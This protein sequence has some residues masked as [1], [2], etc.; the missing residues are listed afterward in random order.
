M[1][2]YAQKEN[3]AK[4]RTPSGNIALFNGEDYMNVKYNKIESDYINDRNPVVNRVLGMPPS[5][6]II[7]KMKPRAVLK[8]DVS[9]ERMEPAMVSGLETNPYVIPLHKASQAI[10]DKK[11]VYGNN[12]SASIY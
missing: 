1:R 5:D 8:L 12:Q 10:Q 3:V 4:G 9:S 2:Q 6:S 11:V 7:G